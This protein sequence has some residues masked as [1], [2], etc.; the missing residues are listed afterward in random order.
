MFQRCWHQLYS[1]TLCNHWVHKRCSGLKKIGFTINFKCKA[2]LYFQVSD[3][4]Y[5][6][7]EFDGNKYEGADQFCYQGD[8][9]SAGGGAEAS[10]I[11]RVRKGLRVPLASRV[12]SLETKK[13]LYAVCV[14]IVMVYGSETWLFKIEDITR[15]SR[16]D[17][18]MI[19]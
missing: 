17:K 19:K 14:R 7:V 2:C 11:A 12:I 1:F 8:M 3:A 6:A 5:D 15:I 9:I 16:A 10:T 18:M 13:R 4:D